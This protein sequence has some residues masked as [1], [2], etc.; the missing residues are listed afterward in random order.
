[1]LVGL[2]S[3]ISLAIPLFY[4][5]NCSIVCE[6]IHFT[7]LRHQSDKQQDMKTALIRRFLFHM[8]PFDKTVTAS[9]V[10]HQMNEGASSAIWVVRLFLRLQGRVGH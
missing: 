9:L 2:V 8:P 6:A 1:M 3:S 5:Y 10:S 7:N 4:C